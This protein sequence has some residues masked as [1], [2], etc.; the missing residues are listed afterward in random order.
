VGIGVL[1]M[2][3]MKGWRCLGGCGGNGCGG[4]V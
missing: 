4:V 3:P 1:V 2:M